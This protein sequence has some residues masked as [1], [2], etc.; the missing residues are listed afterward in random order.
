MTILSFTP[1]SS[2]FPLFHRFGMKPVL[3][4]STVGRYQG[5]QRLTTK[6]F[7]FV[8]QLWTLPFISNSRVGQYPQKV[9]DRF[10]DDQ[11]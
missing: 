2:L 10:Y 6:T 5:D 7:V 4:M 11:R 9:Q 3:R 1:A 8:T